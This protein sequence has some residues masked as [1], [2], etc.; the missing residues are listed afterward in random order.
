LRSIRPRFISL[1]RFGSLT[2]ITRYLAACSLALAMAACGGGGGS[3]DGGGGGSGSSSS[4]GTVAPPVQVSIVP[5]AASVDVGTGTQSFS[6]TIS[7]SSD[8]SVTWQVGG[9]TGGNATLGL[10]STSGVYS[11]PASMPTPAT[12]SVTA[13][14]AADPT[15][16]AAATVTLVQPTVSPPGVPSVPSGLAASNVAPTSVTF[17][18]AA[19][20]DANGPGIGGYYVYRNGNQIATVSS[21][22]SYTDTALTTSTTYSYQ[23]A[24]FDTANPPRVSAQSSALPVTTQA[25]TQA[26]TVPTGLAASNISTSSLTLSWSASTDLPKPGGAGVGGY[27]VYRNGTQIATAT[28][29]S[30][31]DAGLAASTSYS[32]T[33]AA[34]DTAV[35]ANLSA[36]SAA[37]PVMTAA[38][39][40]PPT[41]PSALTATAASNTQINLSWTA[42]SDNVG[43][44][45]YLIERCPGAGCGN[46]AQ[47]ATFPTTTYNDVGLTASSSYSYRVRATDAA[48]NLSPYSNTASATT[49]TPGAIGNVQSADQDPASGNTV[50]VTYSAVQAAGDLNVVVVGWNDSTSSVTSITDS[51]GN[52]YLVAAGPTTSAGNATQLIY[53]AQNIAAAAA[54]ANTVTV[55]FNTTVNFPDVRVLEY[56]G[57]TPSSALDVSVGASGVGTNLS[58]GAATTTHANDLL[59]GANYIGASFAAVGTGYTARVI[60][61]P[62]NDLVED[63]VVSATG[64]YSAGSTQSAASWWVMQMAAFRTTGTA[65]FTTITP[66]SPALTLLQTQQFTTNAPGGTTLNWSVDGIAGGNTTV[67]TIS[68]S[69]LY[70]PPATAGT[71]TVSAANAANPANSVSVTVAVTDLTGVTTYH[72]DVARTGQNLQEYALTPN[73]VASGN[74]G[75]RW[76][77]PLDG[78]VY[79]QPLYVANLAIGG[80]T[81][82]VLFVVT[83]HDTIY[84]FDADSPTCAMYWHNS[85]VNAGAGITTISSANATCNDVLLEYGITG[86]PVID[87]STQTIY[88]V[89]STTENG[90]YFQRLHAVNITNGAERAN[91]GVAITASVPGNADGGT[92]VAFNP[93]YQNQ[94][95]GLVLTQGGIIVAWGSRCDNYLWPWHGW[96]M[97]FDKTSLALTAAF[98]STP[99]ASDGGIWMAGD[100]PALDSEGNMFLSTGNGSFDNTSNS[101]PALAPNND[102]GESLL[103]LSP[104]TLGVQDFYTPSQNAAWTTGDLDIAAGGMTVLPDGVGPSAHPNVVLGAD[105]QGHLWMMDRNSM[106]GFSPTADNTVQYLIL[107]STTQYAYF[108][109]P[110]YYQATGTVYVSINKGPVMALPLTNGLLPAS[111]VT[112]PQTAVPSSQSS[113][114]YRYPNPVVSISA[115]PSGGAVAWVLDNNAT[116]TD[117]GAAPVGPAIL[118]AYD[119][120]NLGITLYSSATLPAD[121]GGNAAKYTLPVVA[122]GHVYIAG[123]GA[124]TVYGLAP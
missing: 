80:G 17:S 117:N 92:T 118:R 89:T 16:Q 67:G 56:S 100:G 55:T 124:L 1:N 11:A 33:V 3:S 13:V 40:Q 49:N 21:G 76:S 4:S 73:A 39:T 90:S 62:D 59:V 93:L 106:S 6:A 98:N 2:R 103:N 105:K 34:F 30:Y 77:C 121:V 58:S 31:T 18:W 41:A 108:A 84:A 66:R 12:V 101:L 65:A 82:N 51:R 22:T 96:V 78:T 38:D 94:R 48:G 43:V 57:I 88:F 113:E 8:T 26:P 9:V 23:V 111:G 112:L 52:S 27:I 36:P 75:K 120:A 63:Q 42:S 69:G 37:L 14:S 15:K 91:S 44:T 83:M 81:H 54:G 10:I 19:S 95:P 32:Y 86:T 5:T 97:R 114:V 47:I 110:A 45:N 85:Y 61:T 28:T 104:V 79:A 116:G 68:A 7:N 24:A 102:F 35:P 70:T 119:A 46:F 123:N 50:S 60:T 109:T 64:S 71:H 25:D 99:N 122:N 87:P 72:N 29:T 20:T 53:Y 107:P 74:F 115:S